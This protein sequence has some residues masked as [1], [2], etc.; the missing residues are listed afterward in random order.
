MLSASGD[1]CIGIRLRQ[2]GT[3]QATLSHPLS[4]YSTP[5]MNILPPNQ[6]TPPIQRTKGKR[7]IK[8]LCCMPLSRKD[9]Q[10]SLPMVLFSYGVQVTV[11][12]SSGAQPMAPI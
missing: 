1:K 9:T 12:P 7:R 4:E 6:K 11:V 2:P 8:K 5:S 3:I 10:Y